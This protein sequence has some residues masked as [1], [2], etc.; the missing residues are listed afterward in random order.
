MSFT[1]L[2]LTL[3]EVCARFFYL[4]LLFFSTSVTH[5]PPAPTFIL[6]LYLKSLCSQQRQNSFNG[7]WG[8]E[9]EKKEKEKDKLHFLL[10]DWVGGNMGEL[11]QGYL[12][13]LVT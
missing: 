10:K 2:P 5:Q 3:P 11:I 6:N 8:E 4:F 7:K 13:V 12:F 1:Q 9:E